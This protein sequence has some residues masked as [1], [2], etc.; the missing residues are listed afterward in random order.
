MIILPSGTG[1]IGDFRN[2]D[3]FFFQK[4]F[5]MELE[6]SEIMFDKL[7]CGKKMQSLCVFCI[8][9][10][11]LL[12]SQLGHMKVAEKNWLNLVLNGQKNCKNHIQEDSN[13]KYLPLF[14]T[15]F[16]MSLISLLAF[17]S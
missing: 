14:Y 1:R 6:T 12:S 16:L 5:Q 10:L 17:I 3:Q 8:A 15:Y 13:P 2:M 11:S 7:E 4:V 9:Y